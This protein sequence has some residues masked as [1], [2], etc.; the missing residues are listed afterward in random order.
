MRTSLQV[1]VSEVRVKTLCRRIQCE[2]EIRKIHREHRAKQRSRRLEMLVLTRILH[3]WY[4]QQLKSMRLRAI[5]I[6]ISLKFSLYTQ[7]SAWRRW[8]A[9]MH[10][11]RAVRTVSRKMTRRATCSA[12]HRWDKATDE[13][14]RMRRLGGKVNLRRRNREILR[15]WKAWCDSNLQSVRHNRSVNRTLLRCKDTRRATCLEVWK[16]RTVYRVRLMR[17]AK[18]TLL[19]RSRRVVYWLVR[20]WCGATQTRRDVHHFSLIL[21]RRRVQHI[22]DEWKTRRFYLNTF[23]KIFDLDLFLACSPPCCDAALRFWS[24]SGIRLRSK[25]M[26]LVKS[27]CWFQQKNGPFESTRCDVRSDTGSCIT[28][29]REER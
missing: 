14:S 5:I 11:S 25:G 1:W 3:C 29:E 24:F 6:K 15:L 27:Q 23:L 17:A 20:Q 21:Q 12:L 2:A 7:V 9:V 22:L 28:S 13:A 18:R 4:E 10:R 8:F 26:D 16:H 19:K